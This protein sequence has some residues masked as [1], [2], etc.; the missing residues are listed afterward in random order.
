MIIIGNEN[1]QAP[2]FVNITTIEDIKNNTKPFDVVVFNYDVDI[3]RYCN[4]ND[5][6]Y[7]VI[8]DSIKDA[9]FANALNANFIVTQQNGVEIQKIAENYMFDAKI[10][11]TISNDSEIENVALNGIDGV[12]YKNSIKGL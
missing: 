7:A 11:Q 9:I 2:R 5:L 4:E 6:S 1:I 8:S 10:L 12:I 3:A